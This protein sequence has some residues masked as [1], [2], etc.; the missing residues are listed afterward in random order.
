[1]NMDSLPEDV[2]F[3]LVVFMVVEGP[4]MVACGLR[5]IEQ[6]AELRPTLR[7]MRAIC[8]AQL[9]AQDP[10]ERPLTTTQFVCTPEEMVRLEAMSTENLLREASTIASQGQLPKPWR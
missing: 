1:M 2:T 8:H 9:F 6:A 7:E 4:R 5:R 3:P 10:C